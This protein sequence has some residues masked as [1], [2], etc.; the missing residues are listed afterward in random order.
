MLIIFPGNFTP[1]NDGEW[2]QFSGALNG[3]NSSGGA[4]DMFF[5]QTFTVVELLPKASCIR[6]LW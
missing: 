6:D 3:L 1:A 5:V 4:S 2:G